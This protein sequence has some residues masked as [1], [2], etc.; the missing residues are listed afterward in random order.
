M[1]RAH[2]TNQYRSIWDARID[3]LNGYNYN[4]NMHILSKRKKTLSNEHDKSIYSSQE[5]LRTEFTEYL[6]NS[7]FTVL[8]TQLH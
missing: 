7:N 5:L 3:L 1:N 8:D 2:K 6:H 4:Y